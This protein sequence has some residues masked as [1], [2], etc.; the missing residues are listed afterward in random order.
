MPYSRNTTAI[1]LPGSAPPKPRLSKLW[2]FLLLAGG[3]VLSGCVTIPTGKREGEK[4][5]VVDTDTYQYLL[6]YIHLDFLNPDRTII[7]IDYQVKHSYQLLG[8]N[9]VGFSPKNM[10]A[11]IA[12]LLKRFCPSKN[13]DGNADEYATYYDYVIAAADRIIFCPNIIT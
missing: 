10:P 9:V 1:P 4:I 6:D 7:D 5:H 2:L 12:E 3:V 8:E 11:D 13:K